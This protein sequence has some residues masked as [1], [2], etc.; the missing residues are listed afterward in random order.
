MKR[1]S[2]LT[3][4]AAIGATVL[5]PPIQADSPQSTRWAGPLQRVHTAWGWPIG[6][7]L[8]GVCQG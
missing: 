2:I 1:R 7:L 8:E 5:C 3:G 4:A 6:H